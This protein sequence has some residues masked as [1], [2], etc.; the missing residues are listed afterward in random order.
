MTRSS[1]T[2]RRSRLAPLMALVVLAAMLA[3]CG[4]DNNDNASD[5]SSSSK[6]TA[7]SGSQDLV[8]VFKIDPGTCSDAGVTAGSWFR[9]VQGGGTLD[10]GPFVP[11]GD[12][13]CGDKTWNPLLPGTD[14]GLRT[15]DY[16]T[17]PDPSFDA[18]GN[19]TGEK[20]IKVV[21][22]FAVGFAA[23]TNEKDPQTGATTAK[24]KVTVE[25]GKLTGD[26]RAFAAAWN[27][28]DFNQGSPKPDGSKPGITTD[29][30]G[31][32][33]PAT[34]HFTLEWASQIVGGPFN[35]FTGVWHLEG[36]FEPA[37]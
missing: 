35:N 7:A 11:N 15:G 31:T 16:Q 30:S 23:G 32:Y 3:A 14:G 21:K 4:S 27:K 36:T 34:K 1:S 33:D 19:A 10:A 18:G 8:G 26:L 20:I 24:P 29:P 13:S 6:T 12:S 28:Q 9:M 17:F 25:N 2:R 22:F 5:A 37:G